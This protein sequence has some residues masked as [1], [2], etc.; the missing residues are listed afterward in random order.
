MCGL[1]YRWHQRHERYLGRVSPDVARA[2]RTVLPLMARYRLRWVHPAARSQT[3]SPAL[4][5]T[6]ALLLRLAPTAR[7]R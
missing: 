2:E 6:L 1:G 3:L 7:C 5:Q 4:H